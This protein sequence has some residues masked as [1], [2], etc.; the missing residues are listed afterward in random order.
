MAQNNELRKD[1]GTSVTMLT[2]CLRR[3]YYGLTDD[4]YW[5]PSKLWPAYRGTLGHLLMENGADPANV[6]EVRFARDFGGHLL[7]GKP[8]E[9]NPARKLVVD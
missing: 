2:G 3:S 8:D 7:T 1:A 4:Y 5:Y 9:Y 6:C